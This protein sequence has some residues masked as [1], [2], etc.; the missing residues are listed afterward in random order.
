MNVTHSS[1]N[2]KLH[3]SVLSSIKKAGLLN[4]KIT[5]AVSGGPDSLALL[6]ILNRF[7]NQ[8]KIQVVGVHLNHNIREKES[9]SDEKYVTQIF[10]DLNISYEIYSLDIP[11][12]SKIQKVSIEEAA[13]KARHKFIYD[14]NLK[15]D[16]NTVAMGH[17]LDDQAESILMH[18][19]RGAG[20]NGLKGMELIST[21][22]IDNMD[23]NIFRPLLTFSKSDIEIYCKE[24]GLHPVVDSTNFSTEYK[25]NFVRLNILPLMEEYNPAIKNSLTRLSKIISKDLDFIN[26]ECE[27]F[28]KLKVEKTNNYLSVPISELLNIPEAISSRI[29]IKSVSHIQN[30]PS[31]ISL[32][33]IESLMS[34]ING[35]TGKKLQINDMFIIKQYDKLILCKN[36]TDAI[37][38]PAIPT[39]IKIEVP[40]IYHISEWKIK[41]SYGN[42]PEKHSS[43][44]GVEGGVGWIKKDFE[45]VLYI[46]S[47]KPGDIFYPSGLKGKKK[48]KSFMIDAKIPQLWRNRIPLISTNEKIAWVVGWRIAEWVQPKPKEN[49]IKIEFTREYEN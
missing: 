27:M 11:Q 15:Y 33:K 3:E 44:L 22:S 48:L 30:S 2:K 31:N 6:H 10:K 8:Q 39:P 45:K 14:T 13:R 1:N 9:L 41:T 25:R 28:W 24:N 36:S 43:C 19:M 38:F 21:R 29:L 17:T 49:A 16:I 40:G 20:T 32:N 47:R 26:Q 4:S 46:R 23:L 37:P 35:E 12:L 5:V 18:I 34:L 7:V 42:T